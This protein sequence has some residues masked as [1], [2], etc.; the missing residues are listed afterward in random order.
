MYKC[1]ISRGQHRYGDATESKMLGEDYEIKVESFIT[2][3]KIS[4]LTVSVV[5]PWILLKYI[6]KP[7]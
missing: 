7:I 5:R 2:Y 3:L 1:D 6:G 4:P